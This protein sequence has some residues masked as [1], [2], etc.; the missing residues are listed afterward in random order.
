MEYNTVYVG[1]DVHKDSYSVCCY[2]YEDDKCKYKRTFSSNY[3]SIL[4]YLDSMREQYG[5]NVKFITGYEAGCLGYSLY[6][7]LTAHGVE[8]VIMAPTTMAKTANAGK[9]KTDRLDSEMIAKC[10]ADRN[11][12]PVHIPTEEDD[13][14]KEYIRMRDDHKIALKKVK[15]QLL[16][17]CLRRGLRYSDPDS[18]SKPRN[19]T[20]RHIKW[21]R[22]QVSVLKGE[23]RDVLEE[24][25]GTF[26]YLTDKIE[27]LDQKI[28]ELS[29]RDTYHEKAKRLE[30]FLGVRTLTA[31]GVISEIGDFNRFESADKFSSCLGM[32]PGESSS[33]GSRNLLSITKAGNSHVR[34]LLIEAAQS[35]AKGRI[36]AKSDALKKRQE[37][38]DPKYIAYADKANERLRRRYYSLIQKG[39]PRNVAVAAVA[40]ELAC[41]IW[42]MMTDHVA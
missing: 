12:H 24:Y 41:F 35:Y 38:V 30:C 11:Y 27:R 15:Q 40:R 22:E 19:W 23:Y 3:K 42:G 7:D 8:C 31:M 17:F 29:Q 33:G 26:D 1:M 34:L 21:L 10:L 36:G 28:E 14:V 9:H 20:Q 25:L 5:D 39:K 18:Q 13:Q 32:V 2:T 16:A 6:N 37:G 4:K